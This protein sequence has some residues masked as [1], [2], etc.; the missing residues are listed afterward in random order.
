MAPR[1]TG[2]TVEE[3]IERDQ[4]E[5][6][7]RLCIDSMR[8]DAT[9]AILKDSASG[10]PI[11]KMMH[12]Q[13]SVWDDLDISEAAGGSA[14]SR[15]QDNFPEDTALLSLK[16]EFDKTVDTTYLQYL[17]DRRPKVLETK[18]D[19]ERTT[20]LEFLDA[21]SVMFD[22]AKVR[23][24]LTE[25]IKESGKM[26]DSVVTEVLDE[27]M[28]LLGFEREHGQSS[29]QKFGATK[30]FQKDQEVV[31]AYQRWRNKTSNVCLELLN[32]HRREGGE[33]AVDENIKGKLFE[34]QAR[35]ELDSMA[36]E[37]QALLI[38]KNAKKVSVVSQL[39]VEGRLRYLT[40][41]SDEEKL[42]LAKTEI[43]INTLQ[44]LQQQGGY[45]QR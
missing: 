20:V 40:K 39:P 21:C 32:K 26:P 44:Q 37:D 22:T 25:K 30:E 17:E 31:V 14:V 9:R 29:F 1:H 27:V 24:R 36:P 43:L 38:E 4:I 5:K 45:A 11:S 10:R 16:D 13:K 6:F 12:M 35:E 15:I 41:L 3:W 33:L 34:L 28:E 19:M 2:P 8:S 7:L 42:E 23:E 18:K